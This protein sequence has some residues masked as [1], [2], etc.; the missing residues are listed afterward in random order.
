LEAAVDLDPGLANAWY[1]LSRLHYD[2]SD[3][4]SAVIAARRAYE[5]DAFL[6][7]QSTNLFQLYETHYDLEQFPDAQEWCDEGTRLFPTEPDFVNCQLW[8][9]V[10]PW[11][12]PDV[13]RAWRLSQELAPLVSESSRDFQEH[14]A[15][16]VV[17]GV[18]AR[19]GQADSARNV[20]VAA[21]AGRELDPDGQLASDE[22]VMR[23]LLGDYDEA[24]DLLTNYVAMN[25]GHDFDIDRDLHWQWRPLRDHPAF[26]RVA[27]SGR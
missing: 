15:R 6:G 20:L 12:E 21:R 11:A 17:G 25:P 2:R 18:L 13:D 24:I 14:R 1:A 26:R 9:L 22:A 16:M 3:N 8:M 23:T 5:A 10:S 4:M 19:A 7:N 27:R